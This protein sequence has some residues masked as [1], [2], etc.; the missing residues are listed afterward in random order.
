VRQVLDIEKPQLVMLTG[1]VLASCQQPEKMLRVCAEPM[2]Q[3]GIYWAYAIGNHDDEGPKDRRSLMDIAASLPYSLCQHGPREIHGVSNYYLPVY[4]RKGEAKKWLLYIIDSNAYP[5][6]EKQGK[7]DWIHTDQ[8]SWYNR[9]SKKLAGD[10]GGRAYPALAFFHIP[11]PEYEQIMTDGQAN[12]A[13][14][15][16]EAVCCPRINSGLFA[17]MLERGDVKGTF[18]GHDHV[19][20]YEGS[21]H[22]IRLIYGRATGFNTYGREGFP[23]GGRVIMLQED[24]EAFTTWLRLEEGVKVQY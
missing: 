8:V 18:V 9:T 7:Y 23:R 12:V 20:D 2:A 5:K 22:G 15:R 3:R 11:L 24:K 10:R 21:L 19:N 6:D 16:Y 13:G 1:D 4:A 17:A 14:Y